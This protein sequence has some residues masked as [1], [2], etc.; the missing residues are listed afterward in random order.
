M[1]IC[2]YRI[3]DVQIED[4]EDILQIYEPYIKKTTITFEYEVPQLVDF[5]ERIKRIS[6]DYPYLVCEDGSGII[7]YAYASRHKERAAYQWN[8][9][10]SVYVKE[11]YTGRG[12]GRLLYTDLLHRLTEQ[13]IKNVYG[14]ITSPNEKSEGMHKSFGF[15]KIALYPMT[16]FKHGK[17][18]DVAVYWKR[19]E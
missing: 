8:A 7:G 12:V 3:R 16:G 15:Q 4:A 6:A 14:V 13:G 11:N 1:D 17:W 18:L 5:I 19:L 2:N 9:E 10:L